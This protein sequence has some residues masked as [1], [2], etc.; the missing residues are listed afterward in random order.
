MGG[1]ERYLLRLLPELK[2]RNI[3]VGFFCTYQNNNDEIITYFIHHFRQYEIPVY[4]YKTAYPNW[5]KNAHQL[6]KIIKNEEYTI[7]NAHLLHAE[8]VSALSKIFF[9]T[10]CKLVVTKHGYLQRF[11]DQYGLDYTKINKL[12]ISYLVEKYLQRTVTKNFAVSKGVADFYV[13]SGICEASQMEVIYHGLDAYSGDKEIASIRYSDNQILVIARLKKFKGHSL[14][15]EAV[16]I[17]CEEISDFKLLILGVGEEMNNLQNLVDKYNLSKWVAFEGHVENVYDYINGSDIIVA[18]SLAEPFGLIV[19]EAYSC[20]K[21]VIAFDVPAF[22]ENIVD[23]E[24]GLLVLPYN[25]QSLAEKI[26]YLLQNKIIAKKMG[27]NG[28]E[29]LK[30]KFSLSASIEQTIDFYKHAMEM[31]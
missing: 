24:S 28:L 6:V 31:K 17:L 5:L 18:P 26:K 20:A 12:S 4:V 13:Q 1:A 23:G 25:I 22:D 9:R 14:I 15:I 11:M 7:L 8:I 19:L 16:K 10:S 2:K 27:E 29:I 3:D 30:N 21:P